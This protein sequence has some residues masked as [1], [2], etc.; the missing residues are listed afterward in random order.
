MPV[1]SSA[2][3]VE[4]SVPQW[5]R[6]SLLVGNQPGALAD[7][8]RQLGHCMAINCRCELCPSEWCPVKCNKCCDPHPHPPPQ[9]LR[10]PGPPVPPP[11][12]PAPPF[13]PSAVCLNTCGY[14]GADDGRYASNGQCDDGGPGSGID[15]H[16][17]MGTDCADCGPRMAPPPFSPVT[18]P[19]SPPPLPASPPPFHPGAVCLNTCG[20]VDTRFVHGRYASNNQCD[21]GGPG[22]SSPDW[23]LASVPEGQRNCSLGTDCADCGWRTMPP[24]SP[25]TTPPSFPLSRTIPPWS[26]FEDEIFVTNLVLAVVG[27]WMGLWMYSRYRRPVRA[28]QNGVVDF[29]VDSLNPFTA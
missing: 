15:W 22:S 4:A 8:G 5:Q 14:W 26:P 6:A 2:Y 29:A 23:W 24:P 27:S 19:P 10:P 16:C 21:D 11:D 7:H 3:L 25:P 13:H 18:P 1:L 20:G 28:G 17:G 12:L 9:P